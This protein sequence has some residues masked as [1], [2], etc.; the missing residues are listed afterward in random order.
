MSAMP[1]LVS[2]SIDVSGHGTF[3]LRPVRGTPF[4]DPSKTAVAGLHPLAE[5]IVAESHMFEL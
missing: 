4:A 3:D 1:T 5:L 2:G